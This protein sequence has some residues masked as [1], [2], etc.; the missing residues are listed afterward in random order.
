MSDFPPIRIAFFCRTGSYLTYFFFFKYSAFTQLLFSL[1]KEQSEYS[2][3]QVLLSD[4]ADRKRPNDSTT[5][6][7]L[8]RSVLSKI[9][10]SDTLLVFLPVTGHVAQTNTI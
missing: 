6:T 10:C 1:Q 5:I 2:M 9:H 8:N 3:E 7:N 4:S